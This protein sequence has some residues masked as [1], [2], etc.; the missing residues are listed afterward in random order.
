MAERG[1]IKNVMSFGLEVV[2]PD[3]R[4]G[5]VHMADVADWPDDPNQRDG[6]FTV[7]EWI[8]VE[9]TS[10]EGVALGL[11]PVAIESLSPGPADPALSDVVTHNRIPEGSP[12]TDELPA[13]DP[14][15]FS[16]TPLDP[17]ER[18]SMLEKLAEHM[19][20]IVA[21]ATAAQRGD[22]ESAWTELRRQTTIEGFRACAERLLTALDRLDTHMGR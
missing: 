2:L 10:T 12:P 17:V 14:D 9:V 8:T 18:R 1:V 16:E 15:P 22:L 19:R 13:D 5:Y 20:P 6:R 11:R 7:G 4:T 3:G 21:E